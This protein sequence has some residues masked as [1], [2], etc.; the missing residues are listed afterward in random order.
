MRIRVT[1]MFAADAIGRALVTVRR[2]PR[3]RQF[4]DIGWRF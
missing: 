4:P 2:A 3:V 1:R